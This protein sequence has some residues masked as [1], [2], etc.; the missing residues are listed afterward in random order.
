MGVKYNDSI[1]YGN[2]L[3]GAA[4]RSLVTGKQVMSDKPKTKEHIKV[5]AQKCVGC[6]LCYDICPTGSFEMTSEGVA[7]WSQYGMQFCGECGM[8]R[9]ICPVD[10]ID[11]NYPEG[12]TGKIHQW[13]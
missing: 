7:D 4:V 10:A 1:L 6:R 11:W 13:A 8:C 9:Y 12:G 5:D 3:A 2:Q